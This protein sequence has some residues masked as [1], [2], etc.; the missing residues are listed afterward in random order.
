MFPQWGSLEYVEMN[1]TTIIKGDRYI[2]RKSSM[3]WDSYR[4]CYTS[5]TISKN[6]SVYT[7]ISRP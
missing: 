6:T 1:I 5:K 3:V 4:R 2:E 7:Y